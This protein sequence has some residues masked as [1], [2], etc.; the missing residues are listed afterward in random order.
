[1]LMMTSSCSG[2]SVEGGARPGSYCH[3]DGQMPVAEEE[4]PAGPGPPETGEAP[5][6]SPVLLAAPQAKVSHLCGLLYIDI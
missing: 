4:D 3:S 2:L 6:V 5:P 1:M